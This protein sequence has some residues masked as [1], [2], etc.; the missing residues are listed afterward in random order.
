MFRT[1]RVLRLLS[2]VTYCAPAYDKTESVYLPEH[3]RR[4]PRRGQRLLFNEPRCRLL[5]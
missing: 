4:L 5:S 1:I 3:G 2:P